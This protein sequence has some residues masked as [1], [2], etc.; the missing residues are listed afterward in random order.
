MDSVQQYIIDDQICKSLIEANNIYCD[1]FMRELDFMHNT[2]QSHYSLLYSDIVSI[3]STSANKKW[4]RM[5]SIRMKL[6]MIL[7]IFVLRQ[8]LNSRERF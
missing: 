5:L 6:N 4:R 8:Q 3:L 1:S 7:G 2:M